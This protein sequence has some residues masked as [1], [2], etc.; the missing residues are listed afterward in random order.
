MVSSAVDIIKEMLLREFPALQA[1]YI[2]G[3]RAVEQ[4]NAESDFDIAFLQPVGQSPA[5]SRLF[6]IQEL[7]ASRLK[8][9]VDLVD[10]SAASLVLK[11]QIIST[12]NLI[13]CQDGFNATQFEMTVMSM[14]QRF[15]LERAS[16]I[17]Q[18]KRTG[19]I[20]S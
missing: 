19:R 20:Y 8:T 18:T 6:N 17:S 10:L 3:S 2:F 12:G 14:Y 4:Q 1:V 5:P 16:L 15:N 13:Y 11:F 7:L 9:D